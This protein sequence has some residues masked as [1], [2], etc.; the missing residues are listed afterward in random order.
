MK[1]KQPG[2]G[3]Q[4]PKKKQTTRDRDPR[5]LERKEQ[6]QLQAVTCESDAKQ[7][8]DTMSAM[9]KLAKEI[10]QPYDISQPRKLVTRRDELRPAQGGAEGTEERVLV[11]HTEM[12]EK[13][14]RDRRRRGTPTPAA[15]P[16]PKPARSPSEDSAT[17]EM[18]KQ[19]RNKCFEFL[20]HFWRP[21][22]SKLQAISGL[23]SWYEES[24]A[25]D[26]IEALRKNLGPKCNVKRTGEWFNMASRNLVRG[27]S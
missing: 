2:A 14:E 11:L 5:T 18:E 20:K 26:A 13:S 21:M 19:K 23:F 9:V 22:P 4:E 6:C 1:R 12:C 16:T 24:K 7:D 25:S 8:K 27:I 10:D 3:T 15:S 17:S